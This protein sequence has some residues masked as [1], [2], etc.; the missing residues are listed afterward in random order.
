MANA[1]QSAYT[2]SG[3]IPLDQGS[4][5]VVG[6][7]QSLKQNKY[8][9]NYNAI[10][11]T[12]DQYTQASG[13]LMRDV[14]RKYASERLSQ[15]V[16]NVNN[17]G[18]RDWSTGTIASEMSHYVGQVLDKN[19]M[20]AISSTKKYQTFKT[21]LDELKKSKP[22]LY[23]QQN[24]AYATQDLQRYMSSGQAGDVL[25]IGEYTPFTD[26][27]KTILDNA[28]KFQKMGYSVQWDPVNNVPGFTMLNKTEFLDEG[29]A[30]QLIGM[31][32]GEK[33][34]QQMRIDSWYNGRGL[35]D[36]QVEASFNSYKL[37][38]ID[39]VD[40]Q[41]NYLNTLTA[42]K[43]PGQVAEINKQIES[44][45]ELKRGM[46]DPVKGRD[47]KLFQM[48]YN[49][50]VDNTAGAISFK[51]ITDFKIDNS[52]FEYDKFQFDQQKH[53]DD[54]SLKQQQLAL[55]T[56]KVEGELRA[57]GID[58]V[59]GQYSAAIAAEYSGMGGPGYEQ[60]IPEEEQ[61]IS[62]I[63][64]A[65]KS[66]VERDLNM[67]KIIT[68][69]LADPDHDFWD[70]TGLN[71]GQFTGTNASKVSIIKGHLAKS[72]FKF[73]GSASPDMVNAVEGFKDAMNDRNELGRM[74]KTIEEGGISMLNTLLKSGDVSAFDTT[75]T[76]VDN[77]GKVQSSGNFAQRWMGGNKIL[78][79]YKPGTKVEDFLKTNMGKSAL[80]NVLAAKRD[81]GGTRDEIAAIDYTI[82]Q[83][84]KTFTQKDGK[85]RVPGAVIAKAQKE[86]KDIKWTNLGNLGKTDDYS[87]A[88]GSQE[89]VKSITNPLAVAG[90]GPLLIPS[91]ESTPNP[92]SLDTA[93]SLA[94]S[95]SNALSNKYTQ[96]TR[97]TYQRPIISG[98]DG[99][100][101]V[102]QGA[103]LQI[104][105]FEGNLY[106]ATGDG[107]R[108]PIPE[109]A[110]LDTKSGKNIEVISEGVNSNGV[111][112]VS[113]RIPVISTEDDKSVYQ[114]AQTG[115]MEITQAPRALVAGIGNKAKMDYNDPRSNAWQDKSYVI[116]LPDQEQANK[117]AKKSNYTVN[118]ESADDTEAKYKAM[119][120]AQGLKSPVYYQQLKEAIHDNY[121]LS[122]EK[123]RASGDPSASFVEVRDG[124]GKLVMNSTPITP[125]SNTIEE[126]ANNPLRRYEIIQRAVDTKIKT[127][128]VNAYSDA[129]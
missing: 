40:D 120:N 99:N 22:D 24:E 101:G 41:I 109:N 104:K 84:T 126:I 3:G 5:D 43:K 111:Q 19:V 21:N 115:K 39:Q 17:A 32:L 123:N 125:G 30:R 98:K 74:S 20:N 66:T 100:E 53:V 79:S 7:V 54:I 117:I 121:T 51:R 64:A 1:Y 62:T 29:K 15:L 106:A 9:A 45:N 116:G 88:R 110:E 68:Q 114:V 10:Q 78:S 87:E 75:A 67:D 107:K 95:T 86:M 77:D 61:H 50:F 56:K 49:S 119:F 129:R 60:P 58:P 12:I 112:M 46:N 8:D 47:N 52:Q 118:F 73:S 63:E 18:S 128:M 57:K 11:Q 34:T 13:G 23:A 122:I 102:M 82:N 124:N 42:G 2:Y 108:N 26:Y 48:H 96:N 65:N 44:L 25:S 90:I 4:I 59:T 37:E 28:E 35:T 76:W 97:M 80:I 127:I 92:T 16:H 85:T 83:I 55:E 103:V 33:D 36:D 72:T 31:A 27:K 89:K 69:A 113:F 94:N 81:A 14:D 105:A 6:S 71:P 91:I 38:K 70:S 93:V